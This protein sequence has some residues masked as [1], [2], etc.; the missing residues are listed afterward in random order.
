[1]ERRE[2]R[3]LPKRA[4]RLR[5]EQPGE[6]R[7]CP[8]PGSATPRPVTIRYPASAGSTGERLPPRCRGLEPSQEK[9]GSSFSEKYRDRIFSKQ[10]I[11]PR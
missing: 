6:T 2:E 1:M 10:H 7:R 3:F 5:A 8:L 9:Q 4:E 11:N